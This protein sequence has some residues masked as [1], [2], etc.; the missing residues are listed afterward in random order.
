MLTQSPLQGRQ[1]PRAGAIKFPIWCA[2]NFLENPI[3]LF[4]RVLDGV[5][6]TM[7]GVQG[8]NAF[9][10]ETGDKV[11]NRWTT[12]ATGTSSSGGEVHAVCYGE[13]AFGSSDNDGWVGVTSGEVFEMAL[14]IGC[15]GAQR[16]VVWA[17]HS[18]MLLPQ[19]V[20]H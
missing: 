17:W 13:K 10:V 2:S 16:V 14:F 15:Q 20:T 12:F 19:Q 5:T 1:G 18:E 7:T 4:W 11:R 9:S 8:I 6:A 3:A